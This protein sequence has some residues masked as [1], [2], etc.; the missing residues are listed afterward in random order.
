[1]GKAWISWWD[2]GAV[3]VAGAVQILVAIALRSGFIPSSKSV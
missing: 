1:M 2:C 3:V